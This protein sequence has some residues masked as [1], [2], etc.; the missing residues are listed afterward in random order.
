MTSATEIINTVNSWLKPHVFRDYCPNGLQLEGD[1]KSIKKIACAVTASQYVIEQAISKNADMLI[2]H[3]GFFWK[4][5]SPVITGSKKK[6]IASLLASGLYLL[7]YHLPLDAHPIL[8]NNAQLANKLGLS[9]TSCVPDRPDSV[10][11]TG[12]LQEP[13]TGDAFCQRVE[14]TLA[15]RPLYIGD[16]QRKLQTFAW[17]TGGAQSY[18]SQAIEQGVDAF[19]TGEVSEQN[20]H[21]AQESGV[22]YIAAGHHAT[23]RYGVQAL[24]EKL[25]AEYSLE[26]FFVDQEN[27][28]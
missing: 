27:P 13:M 22:C 3:H 28:V 2:V 8:G 12:F 16:P 14:Q 9:F 1:K 19:I 21:Q 23:E 10:L 17:C 7:A 11:C 20:Y 5:E 24:A 26:Y 4:G 6:R 18:F 15:R 25:S